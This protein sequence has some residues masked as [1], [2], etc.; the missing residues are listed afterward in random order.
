MLLWPFYHTKAIEVKK[1]NTRIRLR[2]LIISRS[3]KFHKRYPSGIPVGIEKKF[4]GG[5]VSISF[6]IQYTDLTF[7]FIIGI[8]KLFRQSPAWATIIDYHSNNSLRPK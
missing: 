1:L 6:L 8:E 7:E 2:Q 3:F 4:L 5:I